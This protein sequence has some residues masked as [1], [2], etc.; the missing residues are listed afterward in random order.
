VR[1]PS[2]NATVTVRAVVI[3]TAHVGVDPEHAPLHSVKVEPVLAVAVSVTSLPSGNMA[4]QAAVHEMPVGLEVT[5]P[6]P[7][8]VSGDRE[9]R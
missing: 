9:H 3:D 2:A 4:A 1:L 6:L 7:A 5:E 8:P